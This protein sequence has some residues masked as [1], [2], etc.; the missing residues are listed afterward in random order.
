MPERV[1]QYSAARSDASHVSE[2]NLLIRDITGS[3]QATVQ[4]AV[5][6]LGHRWATSGTP[7][8]RRVPGEP[9]VT[10]RLHA[11]LRRGGEDSL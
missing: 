6:A 10:S 11:D 3:D 8:N 7:G 4:A 5:A 2:P 9:G 1:A